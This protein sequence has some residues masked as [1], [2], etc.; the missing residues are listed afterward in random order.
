MMM[1]SEEPPLVSEEPLMCLQAGL[2]S[3]FSSG[4][5]NQIGICLQIIVDVRNIFA[6][7]TIK[8]CQTLAN[9]LDVSFLIL[10]EGTD[11]GRRS[12]GPGIVTIHPENRLDPGG[13]RW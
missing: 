3:H 6:A 4:T 9:R 1:M 11:R 7:L 2:M 10:N 12:S 8:L 5:R 13:R